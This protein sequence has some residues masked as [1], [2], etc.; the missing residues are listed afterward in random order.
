[1]PGSERAYCD[2]DTST[3]TFLPSKIDFVCYRTKSKKLNA[4]LEK[5]N[6]L[7]SKSFRT[8][9]KIFSQQNVINSE[10]IENLN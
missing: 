2:D 8:V 10:F 3:K 9:P 1:M 6:F 4:W 5:Q 7:F